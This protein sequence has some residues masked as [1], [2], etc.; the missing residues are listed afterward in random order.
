MSK[1]FRRLFKSVLISAFETALELGLVAGRDAINTLDE[2]NPREKTA[3]TEG[4]E[5]AVSRLKEEV[6]EELN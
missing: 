5:V 2:L 6:L 4:L 3:A 1:F